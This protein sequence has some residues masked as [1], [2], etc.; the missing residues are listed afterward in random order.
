MV[1]FRW[2]IFS[3]FC[4]GS[5][6]MMMM[7]NSDIGMASVVC[8]LRLKNLSSSLWWFYL[9]FF[10][11]IYHWISLTF[12]GLVF[13]IVGLKSEAVEIVTVEFVPKFGSHH[14]TWLPDLSIYLSLKLWSTLLGYPPIVKNI[15]QKSGQINGN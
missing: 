9:K 4:L 7:I 3:G 15:W 14:T 6:M 10:E 13:R 8:L 5:S 11:D 1:L 12:H 2:V